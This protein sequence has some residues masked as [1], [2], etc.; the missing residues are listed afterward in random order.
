MISMPG[1]DERLVDRVFLGN[2]ESKYTLSGAHAMVITDYKNPD[3]SYGY[4]GE[5]V[6]KAIEDLAIEF[7]RFAFD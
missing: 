6:E 5:T 2:G 7:Q 3:S 4:T 1:E